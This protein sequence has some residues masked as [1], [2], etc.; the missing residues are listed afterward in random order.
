MLPVIQDEPHKY[1]LCLSEWVKELFS[2]IFDILH[3]LDWMCPEARTEDAAAADAAS[4]SSQSFL[5]DPRSMF[6]QVNTAALRTLKPF[7][8]VPK[9]KCFLGR[10]HTDWRITYRMAAKAQ[11]RQGPVL[12]STSG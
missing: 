10:L 6:R 5:L 1:P 8:F 11:Y 3:N 12:K 7:C 2:R 4:S 9:A